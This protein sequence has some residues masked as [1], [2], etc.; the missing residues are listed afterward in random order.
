[1]SLWFPKISLT[2][3]NKNEDTDT[4]IDLVKAFKVFSSDGY[5]LISDAERRYFTNNLREKIIEEEVDKM[6]REAYSGLDINLNN[7]ITWF[8]I[9]SAIY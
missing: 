8:I 7:L 3:G 4:E 1:M 6:M 9:I 2:N 5:V